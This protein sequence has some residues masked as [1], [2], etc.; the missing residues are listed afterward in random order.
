MSS[1]FRVVV[2]CEHAGHEVPAA[3]AALFR[4]FGGLLA[5]HRAYD[6]GSLEL[7][8]RFARSFGCPC[9]ATRWTRLLVEANR[10]LG[11]RAL[12]SEITRGLPA[13][14]RQRLIDRYYTPH[15]RR[16]ESAVTSGLSA[17]AVV[18]HLAVHTF[19]P[20]LDGVSRNADVGLLYDPRRAR[21][22]CFCHRWQR[23]LRKTNADLPVRRNYPYRGRSDGLTTYLR[24]RLRTP[25]YVGIELEVS[26][27]IPSGDHATWLRV[28]RILIETF[29]ATTASRVS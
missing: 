11:H 27:A 23:L 24:R 20:V 16:V 19:T 22:A 7:G 6:P 10:S 2:S 21:E 14:A 15:R 26:Q 3:Y 28:Q 8:R 5:T 25:R 1:D 17:A 18:L 13:A 4:P 9:H 29:R 12:F